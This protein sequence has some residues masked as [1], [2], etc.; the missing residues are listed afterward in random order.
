M[1]MKTGSVALGAITVSNSARIGSGSVVIKP[2][3]P[4]ATV[5]GIPGRIVEDRHKPLTD[6]EHGSYPTQ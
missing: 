5:V 1:V 2:V 4:G 3:L 6:L